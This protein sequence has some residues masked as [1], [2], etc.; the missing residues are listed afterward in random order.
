[1]LNCRQKTNFV[2]YFFL[3]IMQR[4]SKLFILSNL[5]M[6]GHTHLK[7]WCHFEETFDNYQQAKTNLIFTLEILQRY[8]KLVVS[9]TLGIL[10]YADQKWCYQLVENVCVYLQSENQLHT[11][12][13]SGDTVKICKLILGALGMLGYT[14][15]KW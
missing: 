5:G 8:C 12:C 13:F 10:G 7:W 15:P 4:N 3:K 9:V 2:I 6:P 14:K 11:P 1:M